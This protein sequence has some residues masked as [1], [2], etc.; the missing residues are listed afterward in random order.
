METERKFIEEV[1]SFF[2]DF[3][4]TKHIPGAIYA[5]VAR[6]DSTFLGSQRV[7]IRSVGLANLERSVPVQSTTRFRIASMTKSFVGLAILVLRDRGLLR[8]SDPVSKYLPNLR[9]RPLSADSPTLTI[10]HLLSMAGGLPQDDPWADREMDM[11]AEQFEG[12]R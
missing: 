3:V 6:S 2:A 1:D 11:T 8:L 9:V 10:L 4:L 12:F 5:L 7:H